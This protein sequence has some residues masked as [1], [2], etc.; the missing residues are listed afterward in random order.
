MNVEMVTHGIPCLR[1]WERIIMALILFWS[2]PRQT[3][4]VL[5]IK[6]ISFLVTED[7]IQTFYLNRIDHRINH[8]VILCYIITTHV[9]NNYSKQQI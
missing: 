1:D 3:V 5:Y 2:L 4:V 8:I 9:Y 6:N 7:L